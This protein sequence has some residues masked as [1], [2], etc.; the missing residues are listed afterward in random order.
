MAL[1]TVKPDER[2]PVPKSVTEAAESGTKR[3]LLVALR[4][5]IALDVEDTKTAARDLAALTKRLME[6]VSEIES[7]DA[8]EQEDSEGDASEVPDAPFDASAI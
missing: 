4:D 8:Q 7:L 5:R 3:E 2:L 6:V 1:R